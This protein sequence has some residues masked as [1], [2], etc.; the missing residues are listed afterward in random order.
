MKVQRSRPPPTAASVL[1]LDPAIIYVRPRPAPFGLA[2][3]LASRFKERPLICIVRTMWTLEEPHHFL[4]LALIHSRFR[5]KHPSVWIIIAANTQVELELLQ[6]QNI[7]AVLANHNMF[8]DEAV[9]R[10]L[11]RLA[12]Q[13]AAIYNAC[14]SPFKRR[15]LCAELTSCA[16]VGYPADPAQKEDPLP[17]FNAARAALPHHV[18]L[19]PL[20]GER[21]RRLNAAA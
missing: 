20:I 19:N 6:A 1:S 9:F 12:V 18:F 13:H 8:V 14:F 10:P 21:P 4:E 5:E 7:Q 16:H 3:I 2:G 15:E 11:P 17:N